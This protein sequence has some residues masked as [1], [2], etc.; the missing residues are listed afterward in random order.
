MYGRYGI[1][2]MNTVILVFGL[3]LSLFDSLFPPLIFLSFALYAFTIF[4]I[5]SRNIPARQKE[6]VAFLKLW[7]PVQ[8]WFFLQ[9]K[10]FK[11]RNLYKYFKCPNCKQ[12]LRAPKGSG[13]IMVTC[14]KC[15]KQF[16][17]KV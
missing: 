10:K 11:D 17:R 3:L 1:D 4:R 8:N 14:Q 13:K 5:F 7:Q 9:R 12:D 2:K 6:L 16:T 15:R